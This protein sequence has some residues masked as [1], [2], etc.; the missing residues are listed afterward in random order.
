MGGFVFATAHQQIT[1]TLT[2]SHMLWTGV[3]IGALVGA[4]FA[5][6]IAFLLAGVAFIGAGMLQ[7]VGHH[8]HHLSSGAVPYL[9]VGAIA[10]VAGLHF[11]RVRG[12]R[13]LGQHELGVRRGYIRGHQP[14]L[15]KSIQ[16]DPWL[17]ESR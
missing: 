5:R 7:T 13:H 12:L 1:G 17:A 4:I 9:I 2:S 3:L 8:H 14:L 6:W 16:M 11:G 10:L 15:A